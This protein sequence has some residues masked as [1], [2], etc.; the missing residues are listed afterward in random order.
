MKR[1][2]LLLYCWLVRIALF[3][4]PDVPIIMRLRGWLYGLGMKRCGRDFQVTHDAFI[5]DLQGISVGSHCFVGNTVV[6]MGS[7]EIIIEDEVMIA[8]H[9]IIISGNHT[10]IDES[11]RYGKADT[12]MI[13][14]GR[15]SWVA[16]NTTITKGARLPQ[17]SVLSANSFLN[18]PFDIPHAVY[19]GAPAKLV[20]IRDDA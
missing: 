3:F 20:R 5:K 9:A 8:P 15:G 2:L 4:F 19:A 13:F 11:Y 12:G 10:S 14:I 16:G 7:G 18:K 6:I 1:K 17:D